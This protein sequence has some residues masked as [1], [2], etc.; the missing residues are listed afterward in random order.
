MVKRVDHAL[1]VWGGAANVGNDGWQDASLF[2]VDFYESSGTFS[3][4]RENDVNVAKVSHQHPRVSPLSQRYSEIRNSMTLRPVTSV[5]PTSTETLQSCQLPLS[6][7]LEAPFV[8]QSAE[9]LASLRKCPSCGAPHPTNDTI[10]KLDGGRE[11]LCLFCRSVCSQSRPPV[12]AQQ[13]VLPSRKN[14]QGLVWFV[15]LEITDGYKDILKTLRE[16]DVPQYMSMCVMFVTSTAFEEEKKE[17]ADEEVEDLVVTYL[18]VL[19][20]K[21]TFVPLL[22][23]YNMNVWDPE[24]LITELQGHVG[25]APQPQWPSQDIPTTATVMPDVS[26]LLEVMATITQSYAGGSVTWIRSQGDADPFT[27]EGGKVRGDDEEVSEEAPF[28]QLPTWMDAASRVGMAVHVIQYKCAEP[29]DRFALTVQSLAQVATRNDLSR[30]LEVAL[31]WQPYLYGVEVR[32]RLSPGWGID[33]GAELSHEWMNAYICQGMVGH[34]QPE[35]S[36]LWRCASA[37]A[38]T[39]LCLDLQLQKKFQKNINV[40]E[41]G[42]VTVAPVAQVCWAFTS[43]DEQG[44]TQRRLHIESQRMRASSSLEDLYNSLDPEV[45]ATVLFH[46]IVLANSLPEIANAWLQS[47]LVCAYRSAEV[48]EQKEKPSS[49]FVANERLVDRDGELGVEDVLL[50]TGHVQLATIPLIVYLIQQCDALKKR[51]WTALT[52]MQTMLP[53]TLARVVAP[54]LQLWENDK[55]V[56]DVMDLSSTAVQTACVE[57]MS[58]NDAA[59]LLLLD[60]PD[61]IW[62]LNA[63]H[64]HNPQSSSWMRKRKTPTIGPKLQEAIDQAVA[65]YR[66]SPPVELS[67]Q[68]EPGESGE[69]ETT[70][71]LYR[72]AELLSE[73]APSATGD[74][75]YAGWRTR[76]SERINEYAKR[77]HLSSRLTLFVTESYSAKV[78]MAN[79]VSMCDQVGPHCMQPYSTAASM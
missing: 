42:S 72:L 55:L 36:D 24:E 13:F 48:E 38:Y 7:V 62:V 68:F 17:E 60:S 10:V 26:P 76:M 2:S 75:N 33:T 5:W 14:R 47:M 41:Y 66:V 19:E 35:T 3:T 77:P 56:L 30:H 28:K 69:P 53:S 22:K 70:D 37:D 23:R 29:D 67:L 45:L 79:K 21:S 74:K 52:Q 64:V 65:S 54:R 40:N 49:L 32:V 44:N 12:D 57:N 61:Q 15:V 11:W 73:D 63:Y 18:H 50:G 78:C 25:P 6:V 46:K 39:S 51:S 16:I 8:E 71:V 59:W 1:Q 58:R 34:V 4:G 20:L 9:P 31:P 27:V 43:L